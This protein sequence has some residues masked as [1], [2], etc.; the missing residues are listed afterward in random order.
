MPISLVP[1]PTSTISDPTGSPTGSPAPIAA[2]SGSSIRNTFAAPDHDGVRGAQVDGKPTCPPRMQE[3]HP[4]S[5]HANQGYWPHRGGVPEPLLQRTRA[6]GCA[7]EA[8]E[9]SAKTCG[10]R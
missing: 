8:V 4:P 1:P 10:S 9:G 2:A 6:H 7:S 3:P 5:T